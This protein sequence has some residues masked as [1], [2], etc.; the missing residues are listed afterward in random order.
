MTCDQNFQFPPVIPI[1]GGGRYAAQVINRAGI[2][3]AVVHL[4]VCFRDMMV[5]SKSY[6]NCVTFPD[7]LRA[8]NHW[9]S[10]F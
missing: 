1:I 2:N 5:T 8:P 3:I 10:M 7:G 6:D 4:S 9:F